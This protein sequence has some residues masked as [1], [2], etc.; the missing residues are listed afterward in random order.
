MAH[1][2][3]ALLDAPGK[4]FEPG[5]YEVVCV[6]WNDLGSSHICARLAGRRVTVRYICAFRDVFDRNGLF[7]TVVDERFLVVPC[8]GRNVDRRPVDHPVARSNVRLFVVLLI[9]AEACSRCIFASGRCRVVCVFRCESLRQSGQPYRPDLAVVRELPVFLPSDAAHVKF[10]LV[11]L[12]VEHHVRNVVLV[13]VGVLDA[14][15]RRR[16]VCACIGRRSVEVLRADSFRQSRDLYG[17]RRAV[18]YERLSIIPVSPA[19]VELGLVDGPG[20][21]L[22]IRRLEVNIIYR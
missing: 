9:E 6:L 20:V 5:F 2:I 15:L 11:D 7:C 1:V 14:E 4:V 21:T 19:H 13:V 8:H 22:R 16:S 18:I 12:P 17:L 10:G 3:V